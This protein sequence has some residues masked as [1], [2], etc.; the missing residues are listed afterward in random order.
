MP[1]IATLGTAGLTLLAILGCGG[2]DE[3]IG[4]SMDQAAEDAAAIEKAMEEVAE[5]AGADAAEGGNKA[6]CIAY[7]EHHN[8]LDCLGA[9]K[10][11]AATMCPD[12]LD[13]GGADMKKMFQCQ[14]ENSKCTD[15]MLDVAGLASCNDL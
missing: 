11:D 7:V 15:G 8:S 4:E 3:A 14:I 1:R 6:A 5:E 2:L 13:L 9:T 10:L 12:A